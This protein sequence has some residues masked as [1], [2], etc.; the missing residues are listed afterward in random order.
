MTQSPLRVIPLG[1]LGE[2][3]QNMMAFEYEDDIIVVDAGVLFPEED[4]PGVDFAI[5]DITYLVENSDRVRAILITHG[6]EDHIGAL[7]YVLAELDVPVYA[8][9]LTHGLISV[10][11]RERGMLKNAR[12]N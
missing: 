9:R 6:H 8:S 4:M 1:G 7:P 12:L 11:L 2:I 5:P 3:G 10:K